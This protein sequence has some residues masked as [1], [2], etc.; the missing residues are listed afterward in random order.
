M[1]LHVQT[2]LCAHLWRDWDIHFKYNILQSTFTFKRELNLY[3]TTGTHKGLKQ[4]CS[5]S[6]GDAVKKKESKTIL[7][8]YGQYT[9]I[10]HHIA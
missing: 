1:H 8:L 2:R 9:H 4:V 5:V 3:S 10:G 6:E 7:Y